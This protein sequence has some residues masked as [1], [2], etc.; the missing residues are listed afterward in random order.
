MAVV[1]NEMDSDDAVDFLEDIDDE[2][3][4]KISP[5]LDEDVRADIQLIHSYDDDEIGSLI[6]TNYSSI[7]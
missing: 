2:L 3:K 6:T 4:E 1:I 5:I 7:R